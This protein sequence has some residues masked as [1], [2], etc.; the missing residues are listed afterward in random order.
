MVQM[1][2]NKNTLDYIQTCKGLY[3]ICN[4]TDFSMWRGQD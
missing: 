1:T 2:K 4:V 3:C